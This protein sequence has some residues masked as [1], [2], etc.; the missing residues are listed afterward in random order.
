MAL[1]LWYNYFVMADERTP[2]FTGAE[3]QS[4]QSPLA[5]EATP[6]V[7]RMNLTQALE[8]LSK[9]AAEEEAT[10][11]SF[12][13]EYLEAM[14]VAVGSLLALEISQTVGAFDHF[15]NFEADDP[16]GKG[17]RF[18]NIAAEYPAK[19]APQVLPNGNPREI[20]IASHQKDP[21]TREG[22]TANSGHSVTIK[23]PTEGSLGTI[24][25]TNDDSA[26]EPQQSTFGG[27]GKTLEDLASQKERFK[28]VAPSLQNATQLVINRFSALQARAIQ[29]APPPGL[30]G[31]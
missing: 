31:K 7:P 10:Q 25:V 11:E 30:P 5:P 6:S 13:P 16:S 14:G 26:T 19:L 18:H 23:Y 24:I 3:V 15:T 20:T 22:I 29:P 28:E 2:Q 27:I 4:M 12:G 8:Y 1:Y 21:R 17:D 9:V